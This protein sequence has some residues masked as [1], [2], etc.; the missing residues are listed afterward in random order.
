MKNLLVFFL[1][2]VCSSLFS[3]SREIQYHALSESYFV[4]SSYKNIKRSD[5][6]INGMYVVTNE[7]IMVVNSLGNS[8]DFETFYQYVTT[9]HQKPITHFITTTSDIEGINMIDFFKSKG[10]KTYSTRETDQISKAKGLS[11]AAYFIDKETSFRFGNEIFKLYYPGPGASKS[12]FVIW[13]PHINTLYA[14]CFLQGSG[15]QRLFHLA[16]ADVSAWKGSLLA[17]KDHY[18]SPKHIIVTHG[19]YQA[20][21]AYNNTL[22]LL[23]K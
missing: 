7:G 18:P 11:R 22:Q 14:G 10:V 19:H 3:Q 4:F 23:R 20:S 5:L 17:L 16:D 15:T 9:K 6:L 21:D 1:F 12:N 2:T 13:F 8:A